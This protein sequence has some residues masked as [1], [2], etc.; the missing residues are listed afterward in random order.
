MFLLIFLYS[1]NVPLH[2]LFFLCMS[3]CLEACLFVMCTSQTVYLLTYLFDTKEWHPFRQQSAGESRN[4]EAR[5]VMLPDWCQCTHK[6]FTALSGT[7]RV[8]R[9]QKR[10]SGLYGA[11]G[12]HTGHPAGRHSIR[13]MQCPPPPSPM[14]YRPDALPAAQPTMS[15]H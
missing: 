4:D 3:L 1:S 6:R 5:Q 13:T 12:R 14:I 11:R 9:C 10:T 15:K 8:S 2:S 7:T